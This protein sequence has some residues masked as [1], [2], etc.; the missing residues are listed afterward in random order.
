MRWF[1]R[2]L[3]FCALNVVVVSSGSRSF[4]CFNF[5]RMPPRIAPAV[6]P[7]S[8]AMSRPT[9]PDLPVPPARWRRIASAAADRPNYLP[10]TDTATTISMVAIVTR[11]VFLWVV[12]NRVV[13]LNVCLVHCSGF[14]NHVVTLPCHTFQMM[15]SSWILRIPQLA[16][17]ISIV[18]W[19][20]LRNCLFRILKQKNTCLSIYSHYCP[21][22][23]TG[24]CPM[25]GTPSS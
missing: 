25:A 23:R 24:Y 6:S 14:S 20:W 4:P 2:R 12:L 10:L 18:S 22:Y 21:W 17:R 7:S 9:E 19:I 13:F 1:I 15:S 8:A 11:E 3:L 5:C 16:Y